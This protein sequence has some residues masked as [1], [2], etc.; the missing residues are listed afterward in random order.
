MQELPVPWVTSVF[1]GLLC[2]QPSTTTSQHFL[3]SFVLLVPMAAV[4]PIG[5][6]AAMWKVFPSAWFRKQ[7]SGTD[8]EDFLLKFP[9]CFTIAAKPEEFAGK[10]CQKH[11]LLSVM[12]SPYA[13]TQVQLDGQF[14]FILWRKVRSLGSRRKYCYCLLYILLHL[15]APP[16]LHFSLRKAGSRQLWFMLSIF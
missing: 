4:S 15:K 3:G 8:Q 13:V 7:H 11:F 14:T 10:G 2:P 12:A 9:A 16:L 1:H 6:A 5:S